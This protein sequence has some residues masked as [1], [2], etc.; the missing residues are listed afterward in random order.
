M[1]KKPLKPGQLRRVGGIVMFSMAV[2]MMFA[3]F[4]ASLSIFMA[5]LLLALGFYFLFM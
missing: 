1:G 2:G 3:L 5:V 4:F